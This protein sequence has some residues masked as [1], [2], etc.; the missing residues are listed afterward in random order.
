MFFFNGDKKGRVVVN[1]LG[2]NN[3]TIC[4]CLLFIFARDYQ[5][6]TATQGGKRAN[7]KLQCGMTDQV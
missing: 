6:N 2:L 1:W 4:Q 3:I 5:D 7:F